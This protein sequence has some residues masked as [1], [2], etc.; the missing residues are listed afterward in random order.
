MVEKP[1]IAPEIKKILLIGTGGTGGFVAQGLAK[2]IAGYRLNLDVALI[3]PD[4][5]EEKNRFRQNFM[6]WEV[7]CSKAEALA[8]RL[9]QQYGLCFSA[10]VCTGEEHRQKHGCGRN[11]TLCVTCVDKIAPRKFLKDSPL[12]LDSGN[13]LDFGQVI[14]GTTGVKG[15]CS[16]ELKVWDDTPFV[17]HL[18]NAY[19]KAG[20]RGKK[21]SSKA[22]A[23]CADNPFS[24][25][26]CFINEI[27]AQAVLTIMHQLL[28][29]GQVTTP[30][31][32]FSS[33]KGRW[34]P[35]RIT[36][37]YFRF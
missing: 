23:S 17:K 7:G 12:W 27:A 9:N 10:H 4:I 18:P 35:G 26:G 20:L 13:D 30:G 32:W 37:D 22:T 25:Q 3:D 31:I 5:V 14:F 11:E 28:I 24:E 19:L 36:K 16:P 2:M 6:P 8:L 33:S 34:T 29:V 1:Y 15:S 21:D